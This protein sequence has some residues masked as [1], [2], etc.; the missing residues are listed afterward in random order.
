MTTVFEIAS[1]LKLPFKG[2]D[3]DFKVTAVTALSA[4]TNSSISFCSLKLEEGMPLILQSR[5]GAFIVPEEWEKKAEFETLLHK[6]LILSPQPRLHVIRTINHFFLP[7]GTASVH[8]TAVIDSSARIGK[9]CFLGAYVVIGENVEIGDNC[10][11]DSGV[12]IYKDTKIGNGVCIQSGTVIGAPGFGYERNEHG[13]L[14]HFPHI[15]NVVIENDVEIGTNTSID[16]GVFGSTVIGEGSKID[17]LVHVAHNVIIGKYSMLIAHAMIG[18]STTID[19]RVWIAP[20]T[21]VRDHVHIS[22]DVFVGLASVITKDV[23]EG[24]I[25]VGAPARDLA[26]F[27]LIQKKIEALL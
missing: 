1:F 6:Q 12:H 20:S 24:A 13:A 4:A 9:N 3:K 25:V 19:D 17:N 22:S 8:K 5:G 2:S 7:R 23:P 18:G 10:K 21:A 27:K 15:G 14:E 16:R 26:T 11:I